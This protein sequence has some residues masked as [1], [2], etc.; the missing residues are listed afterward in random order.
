MS[1]VLLALGFGADDLRLAIA[2]AALRARD[3]FE[4]ALHAVVDAAGHFFLQVDALHAHVDELDAELQQLRA[5]V[6]S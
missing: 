6:A 4:R 2:L 3:A 5:G 1:S